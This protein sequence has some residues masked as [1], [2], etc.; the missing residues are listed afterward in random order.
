MPLLDIRAKD[1]RAPLD[2]LRTGKGDIVAT[3]VTG[4]GTV[5]YATVAELIG[6]RAEAQRDGRQAGRHRAADRRWTRPSR[7]GTADLAVQNNVSVAFRAGHRRR[8][9]GRS[10][11]PQ[12]AQ[13]LRQADLASTSGPAAAA[14]AERAEGRAD[15][16]G[17]W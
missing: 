7:H 10:A 13:Q 11:G 9:A 5:D 14:E 2:T 17:L 12:P 16:G 3:T 6:R 8:A 15:P 4:A 1:V